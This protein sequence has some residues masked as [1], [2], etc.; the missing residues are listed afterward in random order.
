MKNF[1]IP[2]DIPDGYSGPELVIVTKN[3]KNHKARF[4]RITAKNAGYDKIYLA[5]RILRKCRYFYEPTDGI[6]MYW[7][8]PEEFKEM[9]E[10]IVSNPAIWGVDASEVDAF[11][12][13]SESFDENIHWE[14]R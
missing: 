13:V 3:P 12:L 8:G 6:T 10:Y 14:E 11:S 4:R 2:C 5:E 9:F 1:D 7:S